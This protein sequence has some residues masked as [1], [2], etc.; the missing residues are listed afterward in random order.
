MA[1]PLHSC[2]APGVR[3]FVADLAVFTGELWEPGGEE[4]VLQGQAGGEE[5]KFQQVLWSHD[6]LK[7]HSLESHRKKAPS[8]CRP[9]G[10]SGE[11]HLGLRVLV[12][13]E[14]GLSSSRDYTWPT[15]PRSRWHVLEKLAGSAMSHEEVAAEAQVL[16][17]ASPGDAGMEHSSSCWAV[18]RALP[19]FQDEAPGNFI[20]NRD[21]V[22]FLPLAGCGL[23]L[24]E[25]SLHPQRDPVPCPPTWLLKEAS[26]GSAE[27]TFPTAFCPHGNA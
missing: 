23:L 4:R 18:S 25:R 27:G 2:P 26:K 16:P 13:Q 17:V 19:S 12:Q 3:A 8:L 24:L 7:G 5:D 9:M 15:W 10:V 21:T 6:E 1:K 20:H 22:G 14:P 11:A